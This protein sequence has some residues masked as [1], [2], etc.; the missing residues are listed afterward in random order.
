MSFKM[1]ARKKIC[2]PLILIIFRPVT[3]NTLIFYLASLISSYLYSCYIKALISV[4]VLPAHP[5]SFFHDFFLWNAKFLFQR[6]PGCN[7]IVDFHEKSV[8]D[9]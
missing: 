4:F 6:V 8:L 7:S 2:V 3:R 1:F 9:S 5:V